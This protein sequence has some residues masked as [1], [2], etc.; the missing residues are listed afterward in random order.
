MLNVRVGVSGDALLLNYNERRGP[1]LG[2]FGE[3]KNAKFGVEF[4]EIFSAPRGSFV[5]RTRHEKNGKGNSTN[6]SVKFFKRLASLKPASGHPET[7]RKP[8]RY[9]TKGF[10]GVPSIGCQLC[11]ETRGESLDE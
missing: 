3:K 1:P 7:P 2:W 10:E 11:R 6:I 4:C 5:R 9:G 8:P